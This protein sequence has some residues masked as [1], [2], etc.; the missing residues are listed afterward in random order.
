MGVDADPLTRR[1]AQE[2]VDRHAQGFPLD[3]PERHVDPAERAGQDRAAS[4]ERVPV[5]RLP[6]VHHLARVLAHQVGLDLLD[7]R[8]DGQGPSLDDR[9]ARDRRSRRWYGPSGRAT[10][11]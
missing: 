3:V 9:L 2:L 1:P 7:R 10:A 8:G 4:V 11:A 6:V 5:N